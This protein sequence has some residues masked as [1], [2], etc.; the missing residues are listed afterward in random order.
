[1]SDYSPVFEQEFL[2]FAAVNADAP[3]TDAHRR[4]LATL[5][6]FVAAGARNPQLF[7]RFWDSKPGP[8]GFVRG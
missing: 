3:L 2:E 4:K 6:Q 1:V 8:L 7:G 5:Y